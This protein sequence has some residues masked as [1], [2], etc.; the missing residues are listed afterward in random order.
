MVDDGID[1]AIQWKTMGKLLALIRKKSGLFLL[2]SVTYLMLVGFLKWGVR[3]PLPALWFFAGG[4]LGTYF[5]DA[6][7]A[8]FALSPSP[9][10]SIVFAALFSLV[11]FFIVTSSGSFLATG[12]VLALYLSLILWQ[13]GEWRIKGN[14]ASWYAMV[15]GP[16]PVGVQRWTLTVFI[17]LFLVETYLF[18]L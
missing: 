11:S 6:A 16:V 3:P 8:F 10:R 13:I 12:L 14:L 2:L 17:V 4:A 15:A 9:F 18:V 1:P 7:E 5:L